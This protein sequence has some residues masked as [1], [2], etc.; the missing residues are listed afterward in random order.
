MENPFLEYVDARRKEILDFLG[1]LVQMESPSQEKRC[2]DAL[3]D[4]LE[5]AYRDLGFK[6]ERLP[7]EQYGNHLVAD[8]SGEEG[9]RILFVG[10][11]DTVTISLNPVGDHLAGYVSCGFANEK[12]QFTLAAYVRLTR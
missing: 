8:L 10:H 5:T 7:R 3:I 12:G 2:V 4:V 9:P 11:A 1:R 6:T